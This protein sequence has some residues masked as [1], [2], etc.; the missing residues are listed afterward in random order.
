MLD[1][2]QEKRVLRVTRIMTAHRISQTFSASDVKR[3]AAVFPCAMLVIM[4]I[5]AG[6]GPK[7]PHAEVQT[8]DKI[9]SGPPPD[10]PAP[11]PYAPRPTGS[12]TFVK[13]IAPVV[14]QKCAACHRPGEIGPFS[15]LSYADVQKRG[16]QIVQVTQKRI[17][18]PWSPVPGY[19]DFKDDRSL[20]VDQIGTIAQWVDEG[21]HEGDPAKMPAAPTFANGW[22]YG[23]PDLVLRMQEPYLL[24]ADGRDIYRKFVVR[25]PIQQTCYVKNYD[26]DPGNRKVVH[27]ADI[28]IDP[29]GWS[30]H[31]DEQ[32]PNPGFEGTMTAGDQFPEGFVLGWSP[33]YAPEPSPF[34]WRLDPGTDLVLELHLNATGKPETVQS[35]IALYFASAPP[36]EQPCVVQ[37]ENGRIDI[38]AGEKNYVVE[39]AYELPVD[40]R[41]TS[42]WPHAHYLCKKMEVYADRPDG[43]KIWLLRIEDWDFNWQNSYTYKEPIFLPKGTMLRMR[44]SYDNSA[45]NP[46]NPSHPPRRVHYGRNTGDEM[47]SVTLQMVTP[48][49]EQS[50]V[51]RRDFAIRDVRNNIVI[52]L[53]RLEWQPHDWEAH[54][55]LGLLYGLLDNPQEALKHY[56]QSL[57]I[58]PDNVWALNN[59]GNVYHNLGRLS[60]A[61]GEFTHALRINPKDSKAHNNLG[62]V[63][64][65][66]GKPDQAA[67][68]FE[69]ALR[70]NPEFPEAESN[71]GRV[72]ANRGD[73]RRAATHF[74]RALKLKPD[75][76]DARAN[77]SR[78][79]ASLNSNR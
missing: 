24:Q 3:F 32:D 5:V 6:C 18:P 9:P 76:E 49:P 21:A 62:L 50:E 30:R 38:P 66:Q 77:L 59:L 78:I 40:A 46:R 29:T 20:T 23:K 1:P 60:E 52:N 69:E 73:L 11:A 22:K 51:L 2:G 56:Q 16:R 55:N 7:T 10:R 65:S 8:T 17:M 72:A 4:A 28:R 43:G 27:H 70:I 44:L 42:N 47:G 31:F 58:K 13:D 41:A 19:C 53:G 25:V 15:L 57:E 34:A 14:F 26:F 45:E 79:Q 75:Y 33:G 48:N 74:E 36:Q 12:L 68:Q 37:L 64:L 54:Y 61:A 35:S 39:D 71:L 67:I 63:F